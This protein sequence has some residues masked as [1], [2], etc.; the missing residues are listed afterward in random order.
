VRNDRSTDL[1]AAH[2]AAIVEGSEDAIY[3]KDLDGTITS[4][5]A[6]AERLYGYTAADAVGRNV[7]ML[8]VDPDEAATILNGIAQGRR[9][10]AYET[11]RR[12]SD[13]ALVDV[14]VSVSPVLDPSGR[15]T[16][17][18]AIARDITAH[19]AAVAAARRSEL[20]YRTLVSQLPD[21]AVYEYDCDLRI[22]KAE[23]ALLARLGS[24][25]G[26]LVGRSLWDLA[27]GPRAELFA[28][29]Y[30]AALQGESRS[31]EWQADDKTILDVD[32]MALRDED[33]TIKGALALA[34]DV[35]QRR[36]VER[37]LH[38]QA[39][40]LDRIDVAVVATDLE[41]RI[42]H[43]NRAAE[44]WFERPREQTLGL[45]LGEINSNYG[46]PDAVYVLEHLAAGGSWEGE[47]SILRGDGTELPLLMR[48]SPVHDPNGE[49]VGIVGVSVDLTSTRRTAAELHA[50]RSLFESAF[51]SAPLGM[52]IVR[53]KP[54]GGGTLTRVNPAL[55]EMLGADPA[56][57]R[58]RPFSELVEADDLSELGRDIDGLLAGSQGSIKR[59]ARL[60]NG[61][62]TVSAELSVSLVDDP[63]GASQHA[64]ALIHDVTEA[65][66][67]ERRLHQAQKLDGIGR[68]AGGIAHDFNNLLAVILNYADLVLDELAAEDVAATYVAEVK[69]AAERAAALTRQLLFF[70]RREVVQPGPL[71][72]NGIVASVGRLL[73][74][75]I[76]EDVELRTDLADALWPVRADHSQIEQVLLNLAL[77]GRD[78]MPE[79][80]LLTIETTNLELDETYAQRHVDVVPGPHVRLTVADTGHGMP[81]D[82]VERA[83]EPFFTTKPPG[84]GSGLGL[85]TVYGIVKQ[86]GGHIE[87]YS[88]PA[89][90]TSVR[91]T[92]PACFDATGQVVVSRAEPR[93]GR[94][95][96]I[97]V[98]EDEPAVRVIAAE[99]LSRAGYRVIEAGGPDAALALSHDRPPDLLLTDVV[100]PGMSGSELGE[101]LCGRFPGLRVLFMSGYTDDI[102]MRHGVRE[103]R[104][105]FVEKPFTR[106]TLLESVRNA[107]DDTPGD[108]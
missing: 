79:G 26:E 22:V 60:R 106:T 45:S 105:A 66:A 67:L 49:V 92:L 44:R 98:V 10:E 103:R 28:E 82:V 51:E 43:W 4:W 15:V 38:F 68:L 1:A 36:T 54:P 18:A 96:T 77:N 29:H 64:V 90:G 71:D 80:G 108:D 65:R 97:L 58:G 85:A 30:R 76:G 99:L 20:R 12:R 61:Q 46:L 23:G 9:T 17:A 86:A 25:P 50:A 104:L 34:R 78:T 74:R 73:R 62:R 72:I 84:A 41:G 37:N 57:L 5:N 47:L 107:L 27:P 93:R 13:G 8:I 88:E 33:G 70:G 55:G 35:S 69:E 87:I 53:A 40:L 3:S 6:A 102:V 59:A 75:T 39:A 83:F 52:A 81:A 14:S 101:L 7:L 56:K 11:V 31:L 21:A 2:L 32:L 24:D 16:G 89:Q 63:D 100:M 95:E 42:T 94:G 91:V 19:K 48:N